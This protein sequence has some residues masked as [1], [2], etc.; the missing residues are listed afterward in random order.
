MKRTH[1]FVV[2]I[3]PSGQRNVCP[4]SKKVKAGDDC[5]WMPSTSTEVV[6][7]EF[8]TEGPLDWKSIKGQAGKPVRGQVQEVTPTSYKYKTKPTRM[9]RGRD[10]AQ[11]EL[12]VEGRLRTSATKKR[13]KR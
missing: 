9:G 5:I 10:R 8:L 7:L 13:A 3:L 2:E 11:P 4:A 1:N 6:E 12:I